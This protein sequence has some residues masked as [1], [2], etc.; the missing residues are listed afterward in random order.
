M[1]KDLH[2]IATVDKEKELR[3]IIEQ[4]ATRHYDIGYGNAVVP[5]SWKAIDSSSVESYV[6]GRVE[7]DYNEKQRIRIPY[8]T[9]FLFSCTKGT[10]SSYN[11]T[12]GI[13]LS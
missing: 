13:S 6:S 10:S 5:T 1:K 7:F 11:L 4:L 8:I 12:W 2:L 9:G 3:N